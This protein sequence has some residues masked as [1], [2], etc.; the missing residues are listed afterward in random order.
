MKIENPYPEIIG[1]DIW[2]NLTEQE[3]KL[4]TVLPTSNTEAKTADKLADAMHITGANHKA[5]LT[6][7]YRVVGS[8][9]RKGLPFVQS[10][11]GE[12]L[13]GSRAG[14]WFSDKY[15]EIIQTR[16]MLHH[17]MVETL[18]TL[19]QY[20]NAIFR[21]DNEAGRP[22]EVRALGI[23]EVPVSQGKSHATLELV[24]DG[25]PLRTVSVDVLGTVDRLS[26]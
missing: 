19:E 20:D 23:I 5:R 15:D 8:I 4:I 22:H 9:R 24:E 3:R 2:K 18:R 1:A 6:T 13:D 7:I 17:G 26:E 16:T 14:Y 11:K 25:T 12:R 21:M 10:N